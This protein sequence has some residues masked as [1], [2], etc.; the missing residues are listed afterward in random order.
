ME[1][2][3]FTKSLRQ[4]CESEAKARKELGEENLTITVWE[5]TERISKKIT[6]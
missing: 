6:T 3:F 4:L 2:A 1:V 5:T